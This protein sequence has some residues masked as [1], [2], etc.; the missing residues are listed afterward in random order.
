MAGH[1]GAGADARLERLFEYTKWHIGIYLSFGGGLIALLGSRDGS[2][3]L[4][5]LIAYPALMGAAVAAMALAG[6]AGGII[7]SG[8]TR[9]HTFDELWSQPRPL[10]GRDTWRGEIWASLEHLAFWISLALLV[11]AVLLPHEGQREGGCGSAREAPPS[12]A[13]R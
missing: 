1:E 6:L 12:E 13:A 8:A 2:D 4:C 5:R 7:A 11:L 9:C 3:F 10:F